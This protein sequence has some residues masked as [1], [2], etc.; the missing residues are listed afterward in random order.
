M[1]CRAIVSYGRCLFASVD[2]NLSNGG[3][4]VYLYSSVTCSFARLTLAECQAPRLA[5]APLLFRH[6]FVQ[7][8]CTSQSARSREL[9]ALACAAA[10][11]FKIKASIFSRKGV[12]PQR[13][14]RSTR[15]RSRKGTTMINVYIG[16]LKAISVSEGKMHMWDKREENSID[17]GY[18]NDC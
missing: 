3:F 18:I 14:Q 15:E 2:L 7:L 5:R 17:I 1:P 13:L 12:F 6:W 8:L 4:S 10:M 16:L 11:R 9:L